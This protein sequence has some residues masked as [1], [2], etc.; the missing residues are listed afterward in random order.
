MSDRLWAEYQRS[1]RAKKKQGLTAAVRRQDPDGRWVGGRPPVGEAV[2]EDWFEAHRWRQRV[3]AQA[4]KPSKV[5]RKAI[6][7]LRILYAPR[8]WEWAAPFPAL[9][10]AIATT[11][12]GFRPPRRRLEVSSYCD[13]GLIRAARAVEDTWELAN[14]TPAPIEVHQFRYVRGNLETIRPLDQEVSVAG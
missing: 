12:P 5:D 13:N 10:H 14:V 4:A 3:C 8:P 7:A 2:L 6:Q 9:D 11:F 1:V